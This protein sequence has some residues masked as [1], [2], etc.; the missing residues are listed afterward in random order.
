MTI[1]D[2]RDAVSS[3][4]GYLGV[5]FPIIVC[6]RKKI[7][8]RE[9]EL[10]GRAVFL[11]DEF[12]HVDIS[13]RDEK[14]EAYRIEGVL[15]TPGSAKEDLWATA[16]EETF[17]AARMV[18]GEFD[19]ASYYSCP[20]EST[21]EDMQKYLVQREE[22]L[23]EDALNGGILEEKF[24]RDTVFYYKAVLHR[25]DIPRNYDVELEQLANK[26][27]PVFQSQLSDLSQS[28]LFLDK[29]E[30]FTGIF[31]SWHTVIESDKPIVKNR[32]FSILEYVQDVPDKQLPDFLH[33]KELDALR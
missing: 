30:N 26:D 29:N 24:G 6:V 18:L 3:A 17:H 4:Q 27:V 15:Y 32:P 2:I 25:V 13:P 20:A 7:I 33:Q 28:G 8:S 1:E 12:S 10:S 14:I 5:N 9:R 16:F 11:F 22:K 21:A 19:F 31:R 23:V